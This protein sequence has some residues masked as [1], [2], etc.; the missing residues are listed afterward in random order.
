M[1][2]AKKE[3]VRSIEEINKSLDSLLKSI[4]EMRISHQKDHELME[5]RQKEMDRRMEQSRKETDRQLREQEGAFNT[6]WGRFVESLVEGGLVKNLGRFGINVSGTSQRTVTLR[7]GKQYEFDITAHDG[8]E[9]VVV[10]VKTTLTVRDV[11]HFVEK[12][13]LFKK[14][15][16][17]YSENEV[18]G[19]VAYIAIQEGADNFAQ[20][21]GLFVI[22]ATGDSSSIV[23]NPKTFKPKSF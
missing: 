5:K 22:K 11:K 13:N 17:R 15:Y 12:L 3:K 16:P 21:Q 7:E 6:R 18:Y 2:T 14:L 20:N 8:K 1:S 4:K 10:E 19:A 9:V 23:N